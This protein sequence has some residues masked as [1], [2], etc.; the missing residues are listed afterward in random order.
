MMFRRFWK[1][2]DM[3]V[4]SPPNRWTP[5][6]CP[7]CHALFRIR[8]SDV[9]KTGRCPV[10]EAAVEAVGR[11]SISGSAVV[12]EREKTT[13]ELLDK[14]AVA[15][16]MTPDEIEAREAEAR[17]RKRVY[18]GE[19]RGKGTSGWHEHGEEGSRKKTTWMIWVSGLLL[20]A[21]AATFG[22]TYIVGKEKP[23]AATE[24]D[25]AAVEMLE[26]FQTVPNPKANPEKDEV[27][28]LIDRYGEY[29]VA[30][31]EETLKNFLN[32]ETV[33]EKKKFVCN[34]ERVGPLMDKH[35]S[36]VPYEPE[37][38]ESINKNQIS[39]RKE[40]VIMNVQTADFV[41]HSVQIE[42]L[43]GDVEK[44]AVEW[45]AWVGYGDYLPEE[46]R[47]LRPVEPFLVRVLMDDQSYYNY[48]FSDDKKW[49]SYGIK[50]GEER[51]SFLG[52]VP[53]DSTLNEEL[54]V[55]QK[56]GGAIPMIIRVVYPPNARAKDQVEIV[57]VVSVN[58]WILSATDDK[59]DE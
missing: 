4:S 36:R 21:L 9:G 43:P 27:A 58:S 30:K 28:D 11:S 1:E 3:S 5:F 22:Y 52:Y 55:V 37:G 25:L 40:M 15:R 41:S 13:R 20:L 29:D 45:E 12:E 7:A 14:V 53:R 10:C 50:I 57:E 51:Y 33:E 8:S 31:I 23:K 38:L 16:E 46:M 6:Q 39:Y 47:S 59:D 44:Y 32:A 54:S 17:N 26:K 49:Q 24:T 2:I 42:R 18:L 19:G 48:G 35:Y 34:P 56:A